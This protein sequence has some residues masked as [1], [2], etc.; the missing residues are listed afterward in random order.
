MERYDNDSLSLRFRV[1]SSFWSRCWRVLRQL[2]MNM[3]L[4]HISLCINMKRTTYP[5]LLADFYDA[6]Q[7]EMIYFA[8]VN[9]NSDPVIFL[10][11]NMQIMFQYMKYYVTCINQ[12]LIT[13]DPFC[14][15]LLYTTNCNPKRH[16][17]VQISKLFWLQPVTNI[18]AA[19]KNSI[20]KPL[21]FLQI[22]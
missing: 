17:S 11:G 4:L 5:Y 9:I 12:K 7:F 10:F 13:N 21:F 1:I 2:C 22:G 16:P 8:N 3:G 20:P 6:S 19:I 15:A 14:S 18:R